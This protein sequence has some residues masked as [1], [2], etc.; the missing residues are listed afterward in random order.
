MVP[1]KRSIRPREIIQISQLG[2]WK[3]GLGSL[4]RESFFH[5]ITESRHF[6]GFSGVCCSAAS[7]GPLIHSALYL[8][9][10]LPLCTFSPER[11]FGRRVRKTHIKYTSFVASLM[12]HRVTEEDETLWL[13]SCT[14]CSLPESCVRSRAL[15]RNLI[16]YKQQS[17][18]LFLKIHFGRKFSEM[19]YIL[20]IR[21]LPQQS[22]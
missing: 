16:H 3:G 21:C 14:D 8:V 4:N 22:T 18:S 17:F 11:W 6:A 13:G 20:H 19:Y 12:V 5:P 9:F 7:L 15:K 2:G 1:A 10:A